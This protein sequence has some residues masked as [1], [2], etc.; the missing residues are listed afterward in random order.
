M[1]FTPQCIVRVED[2]KARKVLTAWQTIRKATAEE[3]VEHFKK[4]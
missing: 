2:A 3:I 4:R 1:S